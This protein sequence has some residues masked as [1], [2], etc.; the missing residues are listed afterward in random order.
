M[1]ECIINCIRLIKYISTS[2]EE[3]GA[4]KRQINVFDHEE[5][6]SESNFLVNLRWI[7]FRQ[8]DTEYFYSFGHLTRWGV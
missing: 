4:W 1:S 7:I 5:T 6:F 8:L 2:S 3:P